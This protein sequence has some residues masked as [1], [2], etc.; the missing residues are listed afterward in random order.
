V[1][2]GV[3][4]AIRPGGAI[5]RIVTTIAALA[6][7]V[8][9]FFLGMALVFVFGVQLA[10]FPVLGYTPPDRGIGAWLWH[11][12]LPSAALGAVAFAD[13]TLQVRGSMTGVL[14]SDYITTARAKGLPPARIYFK[15]SLKN[16]LVP[17]VT[18][19]GF[20]F[21]AVLGGTV[22]I[23]TVFNLP[24]MGTMAVNAAF[25]RDFPVLLGV[26]VVTTVLVVLINLI[27]DISYG[28]FDPK[29]RV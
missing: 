2:T 3:V 29:A 24:G 10:I 20:R 21:A 16:A 19:F 8:P 15:H 5:D 22:T 4:A 28:Y 11:L 17:V 6:L 1:L 23:E 14:A 9:P 7:S 27:V 25:S 12:V 26:V 13:L 18:V